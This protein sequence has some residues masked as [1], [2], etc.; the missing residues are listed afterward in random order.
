[1]Y[2]AYRQV[3]MWS[4]AR[5]DSIDPGK[6]AW[7]RIEIDSAQVKLLFRLR[8]FLPKSHFPDVWE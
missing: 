3:K 5:A 6:N 1:M 7:L 2:E 8:Q 4:D